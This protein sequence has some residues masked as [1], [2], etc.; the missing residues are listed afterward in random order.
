MISKANELTSFGL[1]AAN[2]GLKPLNSTVR[3]EGRL[4][5]LQ[6]QGGTGLQSLRRARHPRLNAT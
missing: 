5:L 2:N 4:G 3:V 6:R 1:S